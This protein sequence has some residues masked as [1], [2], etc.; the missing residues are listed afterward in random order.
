LTDLDK[1]LAD[2]AGSAKAARGWAR[3][4]D[5]LDHLN[6]EEQR[7]AAR[8]ILGCVRN[9]ESLAREITRLRDEADILR[10]AP[11]IRVAEAE[12][13][14][15][16]YVMAPPSAD[17]FP[18]CRFVVFHEIPCGIDAL[19]SK[20]VYRERPMLGTEDRRVAEECAED[21]TRRTGRR[22]WVVDRISEAGSDRP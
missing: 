20:I 1:L 6:P 15:Q 19:T 21:L 9:L 7:D 17:P 22:A 18:R 3:A 5:N 4:L 12:A 11:P 13:D 10:A 2:A 16:R 14:D 8:A